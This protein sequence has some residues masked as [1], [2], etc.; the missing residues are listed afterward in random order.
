MQEF[1]EF[2]MQ[3][4]KARQN[5]LEGSQL[6]FGFGVF[7]SSLRLFRSFRPDY[8]LSDLTICESHVISERA[9]A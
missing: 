2:R 1:K 6:S 9:R 7:C 4:R 3:E 5:N 8:R